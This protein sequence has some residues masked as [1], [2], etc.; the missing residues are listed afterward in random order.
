MPDARVTISLSDPIGTIN[1]NLYGHFA[2]HLGA[3]IYGGCWLGEHGALNQDVVTALKRM[4]PPVIRWPG[5]CYADD[6]HWEDGIGPR[7]A[8]PRTVNIHW[9]N[10]VEDNHFGTHE[11]MELCEAVEAEPYFCGN[12]GSGTPREMRDWVEYLNFAG[13][14]TQARRRAAN[15]RAEPY[16]VRFWGVGNENWGCGGHMQ[17]EEYAREYRRFST[18]L[19]DFPGAPLY[20]IGCGPNGNDPDWTRRFFTA[21]GGFRRIHG[22]GAHYYCG[23]AGTDLEYTD[24][25]WYEL[26]EKATRVERLI[27]QQRAVLD[28]FDPDRRVGLI[29]DEWG[30]WH[31]PTPGRNPAFLWQQNTLR[32]GLVAALTLDLFN[33][34]ADKLVMANIAQTVNVLQALLLVE[35]GKT[36][37]TPTGHVYAMYADHQ[38]AESLRVQIESEDVAFAAAGKA[39][40]MT[41]LIGSASRQG[42]SLLITLVN[43]RLGQPVEVSVSLGDGAEVRGG[44]ATVLAH[45]DCHAHNTFTAP[46]VVTPREATVQA[47]GRAFTL[48]LAPQ[49]VTAFSLQ[50]A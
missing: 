17:P 47:S 9:G 28:S 5:G 1:R 38:G 36:I 44:T 13:D 30:T 34:H 46:E 33:R 43:P 50:L 41:G 15:G 45:D 35:D 39:A 18:Y 11:F 19:R 40:H 32:D 7:D 10:V 49:S 24:D 23:T 42:K 27:V 3:C 21:L 31:P 6:Y 16:G 8:R 22:W 2:E 29:I 20:L 37:V 48:T 26:L 14:S 12:V 4:R 25:Q